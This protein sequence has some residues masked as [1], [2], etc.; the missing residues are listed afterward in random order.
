ML[1]LHG[2]NTN[3][4]VFVQNFEFSAGLLGIL[5]RHVSIRDIEFS[6][7][8]THI[9]IKFALL[10]LTLSLV[11]WLS[12]AII[13]CFFICV[14]DPLRV[15]NLMSNDCPYWLSYS[16]CQSQQ[17]NILKST[18]P[19]LWPTIGAIFFCLLYCHVCMHT[20]YR[21]LRT[22]NIILIDKCSECARHG[23]Q[24][25]LTTLLKSCWG[26]KFFFLFLHTCMLI[27]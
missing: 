13:L 4:L 15:N 11:Y 6:R 25:A 5:F 9:F 22:L 17:G 20:A 3:I 26:I 8:W 21:G 2:L 24:H 16:N 23:M 27:L 7:E 12:L 18:I 10:F 1:H 14:Y 19:Q